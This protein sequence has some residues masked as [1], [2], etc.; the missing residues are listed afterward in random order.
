MAKTR[1]IASTQLLLSMLVLGGVWLALPARWA[2]VDVPATVLGVACLIA[3]LALFFERAWALRFAR[4]VLWVELVIG[5]LSASLLGLSAAQL[6]GSYGPV[7]AGGALLLLTIAV[8]VL[9]Y[10]V[11]FPALQLRWL[12]NS[13]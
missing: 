4:I 12:R 8:L 3:A 1:L 2:W 9:P 10:L 6:A 7:G 11:I 13:T 5:T